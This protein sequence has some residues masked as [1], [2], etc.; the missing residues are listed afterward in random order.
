MGEGKDN[1]AERARE[2]AIADKGQE[3][4]QPPIAAARVR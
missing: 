3:I 2:Q 4:L 1:V